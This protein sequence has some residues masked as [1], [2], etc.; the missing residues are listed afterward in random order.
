MW[1]SG[2]REDGKESV[3]YAESYEPDWQ[4][5]GAHLG[6]PSCLVDSAIYVF[7]SAG[8]GSWNISPDVNVYNPVTGG[9]KDFN[10]MPMAIT[11]GSMGVIGDKIYLVGGW[12][13]QS[14]NQ[15]I[16]VNSILEYDTGLDSWR[17]LEAASVKMGSAISCVK[18]F[19]FYL[20]GGLEQ[21]SEDGGY[22]PRTSQAWTY[23]PIREIWDSTSLPGMPF[24]HVMHGSAEVV[25]GNIYVLS[26]VG[27]GPDFEIQPSEKFDGETWETIAYMPIPV[28]LFSSIVHDQ[29]I[30]V[31]GGDSA[32]S[33]A[34]SFST[35]LIQEYDPASDS[36]RL[37][38]PMPFQ[39]AGMAG[40][41][42]GDYL[43]LIGGYT[44]DRE[45]STAKSEVWSYHLDSLKEWVVPC[46]GVLI[47]LDSLKL[48]VD[49]THVLTAK[50]Q[51]SYV[52]D[53]T[54]VWSSDNE[55]VAS[56]S[57]DGMVTGKAPGETRIS[58]SANAG[59]CLA[60][61]QVV[62]QPGVGM[63]PRKSDRFRIFPNPAEDQISIQADFYGNKWLKI[64]TLNGQLIYSEHMEGFT[65]QIDLRSY[66]KGIYFI[67][68]SVRDF[69]T[70]RKIIKLK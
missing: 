46:S 6:G 1:Y 47:N 51:P 11:D 60:S 35:N 7:N 38:E 24:P 26:G 57:S 18:D 15:W 29:K 22:I 44:Q 37:M 41:K 49:S 48:Q 45:P 59:G 65:H 13:N 31:F 2:N 10:P 30:L 19:L 27:P 61:C 56:V 67:S 3:G 58:A 55:L 62:V 20:F 43:Y 32:W 8:S 40:E 9:W 34:R 36:W 23:D 25:D 16:T 14:L 5:L 50:V 64:S 21:S 28:V 68:V 39:R 53:R 4:W 63:V 66:P 54:V 33:P 42:V 52:A 70:T 17:Q 69:V 12:K